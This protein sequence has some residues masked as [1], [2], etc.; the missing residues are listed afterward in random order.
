M[1]TNSNPAAACKSNPE[2]YLQLLD[3]DTRCLLERYLV[4]NLPELNFTCD[5]SYRIPKVVDEVT[6][7]LVINDPFISDRVWTTPRPKVAEVMIFRLHGVIATV[8][9]HFRCIYHLIR[10]DTTNLI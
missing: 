7:M 6:T 10:C 5:D 1:W 2:Y 4:K 9:E 8:D 3:K